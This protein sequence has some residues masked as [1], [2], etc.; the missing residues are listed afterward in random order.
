LRKNGNAERKP[1]AHAKVVF[2]T[3]KNPLSFLPLQ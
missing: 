1:L 3:S 2:G